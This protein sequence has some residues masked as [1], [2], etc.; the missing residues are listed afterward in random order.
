MDGYFGMIGANAKRAMATGLVAASAIMAFPT[1][2]Y[3]ETPGKDGAMVV[4][5]SNTVLNEYAIL[6]GSAPAGSSSVNVTNRPGDLPSLTAGDLV[7]IYQ[8]NGATISGA[9]NAS[10]GTITNISNAGRYEFQTVASISGN[11]INFETYLGTCAG[12]TYSYGGGDIQVI[13]EPQYTTLTINSGANVRAPAWDGSLGSVVALHVRD[14]F[15]LSGDINVSARGF[16]GGEVDN[17]TNG[18]SFYRYSDLCQHQRSRRGRKRRKHSWV[19][20]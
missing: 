6:S 20:K 16:R 8:A 4:S 10:Y 3:A 15:T 12:L 1:L 13:R 11:T 9:N 18:P 14:G 2:S 17:Q 7:L 5:S 19:S